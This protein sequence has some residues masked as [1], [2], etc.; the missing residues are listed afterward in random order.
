MF[1]ANIQTYET[2]EVVSV[3]YISRVSLK[4]GKIR[5]H[6]GE[7]LA[8]LFYDLVKA[9]KKRGRRRAAVT[10]AANVVALKDLFE[11]IYCFAL[12]NVDEAQSP[13]LVSS[14]KALVSANCVK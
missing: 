4:S 3:S 5:R 12:E 8:Q 10:K 13:V 9:T 2:L 7:F 1:F 6:R 14:S 11:A